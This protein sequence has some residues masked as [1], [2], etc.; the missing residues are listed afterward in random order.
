M[1]AVYA[2]YQRRGR[3][4][5]LR[6]L[7]RGSLDCSSTHTSQ[8]SLGVLFASQGLLKRAEFHCTSLIKEQWHCS[9]N[10]TGARAQPHLDLYTF[11]EPSQLTDVS[12]AASLQ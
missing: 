2:G 12:D 1:T 7:W 8:A 3:C 9:T 10:T 5:P 11:R 6:W 4:I